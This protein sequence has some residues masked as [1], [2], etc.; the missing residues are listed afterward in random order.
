M[1]LL[2]QLPFLITTFG[3]KL[4]YLYTSRTEFN[5]TIL[6]IYL[7]HSVICQ[8]NENTGKYAVIPSEKLCSR[9]ILSWLIRENHDSSVI[10]RRFDGKPV[11]LE[12]TVQYFWS[13]IMILVYREPQFRNDPLTSCSGK[14][15]RFF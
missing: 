5:A 14:L 9:A 2:C 13:P 12:H 10:Q 11:A 8:Y 1:T 6:L 3:V 7:E 4:L 15:K